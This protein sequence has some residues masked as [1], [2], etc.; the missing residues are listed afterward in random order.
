MEMT[1]TT[2]QSKKTKTTFLRKLLG[3]ISNFVF[4]VL[5]FV[6]CVMVFGLVQ[7]RIT[8]G[9]PSIAGRQMYIVLSGS[10]SPTFDAGSVVFVRP[11]PAG[12]IKV[13][14]IVTYRARSGETLVTHRVVEVVD[15]DGEPGFVTRGDANDVN[16]EGILEAERIVGKV[17][18]YLPYL[19]RVMSFTQTKQGLI[20]LIFIPGIIIILYELKNIIGYAAALEREKLAKENAGA[21]KQETLETQP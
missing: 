18:Y 9:P 15:V 21:E 2:N 7:S 3:F 8:G 17:E 1:P 5:L 11:V 6:M 4:L 16:D 10:M 20:T 14:D 19:G 13:G 12:E